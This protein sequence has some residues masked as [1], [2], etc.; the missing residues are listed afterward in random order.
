M[1]PIAPPPMMRLC[2]CPDTFVENHGL[3]A[4]RKHFNPTVTPEMLAADE[5]YK[6]M[7]GPRVTKQH[8]IDFIRYWGIEY[9][10]TNCS[11]ESTYAEVAAD[12][13][14]LAAQILFYSKPVDE[15]EQGIRGIRTVPDPYYR[16][17]RDLD[18][19]LVPEPPDETTDTEFDVDKD[20]ICTHGIVNYVLFSN[21]KIPMTT[22]LTSS[23][24]A[25]WQRCYINSLDI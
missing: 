6:D 14:F 24:V 16:K 19:I 2:T 23:S 17:L 20:Y 10:I 8:V 1:L 3:A 15:I 13:D 5:R 4:Y 22:L 25:L 18:G 12:D 21:S 7:W 11:P 9:Y